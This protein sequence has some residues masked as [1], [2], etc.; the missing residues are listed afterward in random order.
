MTAEVHMLGD[1]PTG[2][3]AWLATTDTPTIITLII[4]ALIM[5]GALL[6][7]ADII[8]RRL[9]LGARERARIR[10]EVWS[11]HRARAARRRA[12][13]RAR[14]RAVAASFMDTPGA[15]RALLLLL[16]FTAVAATV[17]SAHGIQDALTAAGLD[18]WWVR[19][20]GFA[21]FEGFMLTMFAL[22]WWH[23]TT[24]QPGLDIYGLCTWAGSFVLA[25][26]GYH[27]GGDWIYLVF[28]PLAAFGFHLTAGAERRRRGGAASWFA[29]AA[30]ALRRR[31]EAALVWLG[32]TPTSADTNR[33][34][35]ERRLNRVA[36]RAVKAHRARRARSWREWRFDV[37]VHAAQARGLLD[38]AGRA[39][40]AELVATRL[41]AL[42][43]L[44]PASLD[45]LGVGWGAPA[46]APKR[47]AVEAAPEPAPAPAP[48]PAP[49]AAP[50]PV[51]E[52]PR[53]VARTAAA[54]L[55][56]FAGPTDAAEWSVERWK[57]TGKLPTGAQL[58]EKYETHP[59]NARKWLAPARSVL[60]A[61]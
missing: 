36:A 50:E 17:L 44:A 32:R 48:E 5:L 61:A 7:V 54:I 43:A 2:A 6:A 46:P 40:V 60:E 35:R 29:R 9:T 25:L 21:A 19:L 39:Y 20:C 27:G 47:A 31:F 23:I 33:T 1:H 45:A 26:V 3:P 57:A 58:G 42:N 41:G 12:R 14:S 10:A 49:V 38:A 13:V 53:E 30:A 22:S 15:R 56:A 4:A 52:D 18:S 11:V 8:A 16:T 34:D 24:S 37:A 59:G 55:A 28:A 51:A